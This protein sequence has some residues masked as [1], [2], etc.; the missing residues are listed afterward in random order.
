MVLMQRTATNDNE[1]QRTSNGAFSRYQ[2]SPV[3]KNTV[4]A[5]S[6]RRPAQKT[7]SLPYADIRR[8]SLSFVV[9]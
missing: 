4:K 1:W 5:M 3:S 7:H 6:V 9:V 8:R 2:V